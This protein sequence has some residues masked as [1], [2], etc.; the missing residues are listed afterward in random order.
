MNLGRQLQ[1]RWSLQNPIMGELPVFP[2]FS[3]GLATYPEHGQDAKSLIECANTALTKAKAQGRIQFCAYSSTISR[4]I[5]ERME[6]NAEL[7]QAINHHQLRL[8]VQLQLHRNGQ[9]VGGEMLLRWTNRMG[10]AV[11][12]S[13][14]IPLAE[15]SGMIL[16]LLPGD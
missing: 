11:P 2:T 1:Q 14:F 4:Q 3:I 7:A 15:E 9:L 5:Q 10:V 13:H 12:P 16:Q 6:L 8:V